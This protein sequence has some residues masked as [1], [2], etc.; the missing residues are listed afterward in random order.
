MRQRETRRV[1]NSILAVIWALT[2]L[3]TTVGPI[4]SVQATITVTDMIVVAVALVGTCSLG[5]L[6]VVR[7][8]NLIGWLLCGG[9]LL[10]AYQ[11]WAWTRTVGLVEEWLVTGVLYFLGILLVPTVVLLFPDG[12]LPSPR[13]WPVRWLGI[14]AFTCGSL[15]TLFAPTIWGTDDP[16]PFAGVL[17]AGVLAA[18]DILSLILLLPFLAAVFA[19]PIVRYRRAGSQ[20]RLQFKMFGF[21]AAVALAGELTPEIS[22]VAAEIF[23][24]VIPGAI[25]LMALPISITAA[26]MRYRLYDIERLISRTVGYAIVVATLAVIYASGAV[27]LPTRIVGE[28]SPIFVAGSTLAVAALFNPIRR[29]VIR[30]IDRRFYRS[31][32]D[33]EQV[34]A[35]FGERVK[36][37]L[38]LDR[39]TED[40][41]VVIRQTLRPS[42]AGI[43]IRK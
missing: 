25:S 17:P 13:W 30:R 38:D 5:V 43:W 29:R 18:L 19:A 37:E 41:L 16:T 32:Y 1:R 15:S 24:S 12:R 36:D 34:L 26:I 31:R 9:G 39:L 35:E 42:S 4:E 27:W 3:M 23:Q 21:G 6:I 8:G 20:Q 33:A 14:G 11:Y 2:A 28:Q 22:P 40:S 7:A 10:L